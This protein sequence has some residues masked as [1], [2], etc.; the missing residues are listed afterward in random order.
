MNDQEMNKF[1]NGMNKDVNNTNISESEYVKAENLG[2]TPETE[3][4][5]DLRPYVT[6]L[7]KLLGVDV[8]ELIKRQGE[9]ASTIPKEQLEDIDEGTVT[10]VK[11]MLDSF[12]K[13]EFVFFYA[14]SLV[15]AIERGQELNQAR[16]LLSMFV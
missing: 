12:T 14:A 3:Q 4:T 16:Q 13:E 2:L 15:T 1:E 6:E 8:E 9:V 5:Q 7:Q 11:T 10:M